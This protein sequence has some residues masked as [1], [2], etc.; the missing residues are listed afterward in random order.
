MTQQNEA[1]RRLAVADTLTPVTGEQGV[2]K[3]LQE[4]ESVKRWQRLGE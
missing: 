4:A 1:E 3:T 2:Y